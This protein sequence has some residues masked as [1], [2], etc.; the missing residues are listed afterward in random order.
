[1]LAEEWKKESQV[2]VFNIFQGFGMK[3]AFSAIKAAQKE[4]NKKVRK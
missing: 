2:A 4:P 3:R 1:L